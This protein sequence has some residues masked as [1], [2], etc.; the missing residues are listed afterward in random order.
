MNT[1]NLSAMAIGLGLILASP[2]FAQTSPHNTTAADTQKQKTQAG[3]TPSSV[4]GNAQKQKS[5]A[6]ETPS[7]VYGDAQKQKTQALTPSSVYGDAAKKQ[8]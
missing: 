8:Q 6:G 7:S 2:A 1:R 4:Y 3:E 5:Q